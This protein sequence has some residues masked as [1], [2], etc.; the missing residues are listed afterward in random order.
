MDCTECGL[1]ITACC[2]SMKPFNEL[3]NNNLENWK[4]SIN[5]L[6]DKFSVKGSIEFH[7]ACAGCGEATYVKLLTQLFS[8]IY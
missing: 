4:Y 7:G 5:K 2:L 6:Y 8:D 3:M 1:C